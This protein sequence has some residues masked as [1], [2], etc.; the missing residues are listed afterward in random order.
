MRQFYRYYQTSERSKWEL[1]PDHENVHSELKLKG[2]VRVSFLALDKVIDDETDTDTVSYRGHFYADIDSGDLTDSIESARTFLTHLDAAGVPPS[3][4]EIYISGSKGFH[5]YLHN[6]LYSDGRPLKGLPRLFKAMA[7]K[8]YVPGLDFQPYSGGRGNLCRLEGVQREDNKY[9]VRVFADEVRSMTADIYKQMATQPRSGVAFTPMRAP[10]ALNPTLAGFFSWAQE[11][12]KHESRRRKGSCIADKHLAQFQGQSPQCVEDLVSGSVAQST[13]FNQSAMQL[14]IYLARSG[15]SANIQT[16]YLDRAATNLTSTAYPAF[17]SRKTHLKAQLAYHQNR[18]D[19]QFSCP[20]MRS[21]ISTSPCKGCQLENTSTIKDEYEV[22]EKPDGYYALTEKDERRLTSFLIVPIGEVLIRDAENEE[23]KRALVVARIEANHENLGTLRLEETCWASRG[24]LVKSVEGMGNLK[25]T[26]SDNDIQNIKHYVLRDLDDLDQQEV[27]GTLGLTRDVINNK[28]RYTWVEYGMSI[29]KFLISDTHLL[30]SSV[31]SKHSAMPAFKNVYTP[32]VQDKSVETALRHL[33]QL[34]LPEAVAPIL[35]WVVS[36]HLKSHL[37]GLY[38]Q[39]PLLSL[40]GSRGSGKTRTASVFCLL[41]GV[42]YETY[43]PPTLPTIT[44]FALIQ[45]LCSTTTVPRVLD[46]YNKSSM[47][48]Q[49]RYGQI[50]EM[51]K[52]TFNNSPEARGRL[53]G[54]GEGSK[55]RGYGA[56]VDYYYL[57][58]PVCVLSEHG[59]ELPALVDR[60]YKV[61]MTEPAIQTRQQ[62]MEY[63]Q[64][65]PGDLIKLAKI[66]MIRAMNTRD[67]WVKE[68][69]E[70]WKKAIPK[71]YSIRQNYVRQVIGVGLDYLEMVLREELELDLQAEIAGMR[72]A[73]MTRIENIQAEVE[74]SGYSTEIDMFFDRLGELMMLIRDGAVTS[75]LNGRHIKKTDD[76][77]LLLDV[78]PVFAHLQT[79]I[80][81]IRERKPVSS[82][83]QWLLLLRSEPYYCGMVQD[84]G[85]SSTRLVAKLSLAEMNKKG[86]DVSAF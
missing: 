52:K 73:Y 32:K 55:V 41:N 23:S 57:T 83:K 16:T 81:S 80:T 64:D 65:H 2:A 40:W 56:V 54:R 79:Y 69:M 25:V 34:N 5:F 11:F 22:I 70:S 24:N 38:S 17:A 58:S 48:R 86:I 61:M 13:T 45:T 85:M 20:A 72:Q 42:D 76:G 8:L 77:F 33:L 53:A 21:V 49:G 14:A 4:Y 71:G 6:R 60:A 26:A 68:R 18:A 28:P 43:A 12:V 84:S 9:K 46:E 63:I 10:A 82:A 51:L 36:C 47:P 37:M 31:N 29:N 7:M 62:H 19:L 3:A 59:L 67:D 27:V 50:G 30:E 74:I 44:D 39:F 15:T 78:P 66:L 1:A 35:G 75:S